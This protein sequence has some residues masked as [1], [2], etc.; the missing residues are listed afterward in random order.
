MLAAALAFVAGLLIGSFL[1]VCIYRL[2]RDL[3]VAKPSRSFCPSCENTIAWYDNIPV[4]S[5]ILLRARC[6]QCGAHISIRYPLVELTTA[7]WFAWS[8]YA[9]GPVPEA[10]RLCSFGAILIALVVTD[11][12][13]Q[14]LP[15]EFTLG[16][17]VLG[18]V[19]SLAIPVH[20]GIAHMFLYDQSERIAS[21]G[22]AGLGA[23]VSSL[24][25]WLLRWLYEKVRH[26]EGL[27][28]GDVKMVA[29]IGA[30][31]GLQ[32]AIL[33][34]MV[35][36]VLGSVIGLAFVLLARKNAATFE[37]PYGSF[38]GIAGLLVAA[39]FRAGF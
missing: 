6:R 7:L 24:V 23:A 10:L 11:Y 12:E 17:T 36:S 20:T 26:R 31:L 34:I 15:D 4:L 29:M 28:L 22:E 21:L 33:T 8:V 18:I 13:E 1:N 30:F 27:G 16:G 3:S 14:I 35:G 9:L 38:L 19:L 25:L 39:W 32:G 5:Y 37:L 2:P